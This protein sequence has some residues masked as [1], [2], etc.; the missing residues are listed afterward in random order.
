MLNQLWGYLIVEELI[1]TGCDYFVVSPGSRS[2]PLTV[3]IARN[4]RARTIIC[5]DERGAGFHAVGYARATGKPAVLIC[6]SGSAASNYYPAIIEAAIEFLPLII[7]SA[8]RPPELRQTGANQTIDRVNIYGDYTK[9]EF[10]LPCPTAEIQPQVVL[11]TIDSLVSKAISPTAGVVSLN[12]MFREPLAPPELE[13]ELPASL[14]S[15]NVS[16][17]PYTSYSSS[18]IIATDMA[19]SELLEVIKNTRNG[20]IAIGQLRSSSEIEAVAAVAKVLNWPVFADIRSGLR[21]SDRLDNIIHYYDRLLLHPEKLDLAVD[22]V[23]QIGTRSISS[24]YQK[25][26][27]ATV[28][29]NYILISA[30]S[31]RFDPGHI[32]SMRVQSDITNLCSQLIDELLPSLHSPILDRLLKID[33]QIDREIDRFFAQNDT[34][35]EPLICRQVMELTPPDRG[36]WIANSMPV[37]DFDMYAPTQSNITKIG[38]N[39][40]TSGIEGAIAS[41]TGFAIGLQTPITAV[42]GDLSSLHDLNSLLLLKSIDIPITVV[43]INNNGGGIF[44]FLPIAKSTDLFDRYFGTPHAINF[45]LAAKMFGINYTHPQTKSAFIADYQTAIRSSHHTI[46]EVTTDRQDNY[47]LHQLLP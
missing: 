37:R 29:S 26:L 14:A 12:C 18:L 1:H 11:T 41:A 34:L 4:K 7:I 23:I 19:I 32:V 45:E 30:D 16:D 47:H 31:D 25:W 13:L 33:S 43:I 27:E 6:T 15:W 8:D 42:I 44:S 3:A 35:S 5:I 28:P 21:S 10:D 20:M 40:G 38:T 46:I 24:R 2:T 36:L 17:R 22:T 9:W 39:R